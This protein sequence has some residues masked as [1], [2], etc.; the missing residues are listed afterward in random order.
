LVGIIE[1]IYESPNETL[2]PGVAEWGIVEA[3]QCLKTFSIKPPACS[4]ICTHAIRTLL[5]RKWTAHV[6]VPAAEQ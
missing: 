2:R 3:P 4:T 5:R 1:G 6:L